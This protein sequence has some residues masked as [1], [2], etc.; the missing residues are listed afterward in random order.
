MFIGAWLLGI[1]TGVFFP[2]G[3]FLA[4]TV[5][6]GA[7]VVSRRVQLRWPMAASAASLVFLGVVLG[8]GSQAHTFPAHHCLAF[9]DDFQ[10][11][12]IQ[13]DR[14]EAARVQYVIRNENDCTVLV[15]TSRWP[16]YEVG[17][18]VRLTGSLQGVSDIP[19]EY[20]GYAKYLER[21]RISAT[22]RY[23]VVERMAT[24]RPPYL[25]S[26]RHVLDKK[27]QAA[28]SEPEA[29]VASAMVLG[30]LG[31]I[32]QT[33]LDQFRQLG[34]THILAISGSNI[35]LLVGMFVVGLK[36]IPLPPRWQTTLL[37]VLL[38]LYIGLIA[39][40]IS[41]QRAALFWTLALLALRLQLL[42]SLVTAI[43]MA[44]T[45]MLTWQPLTFQDVGFQLSF[46]AVIGIGVALLLIRPWLPRRPAARFALGLVLVSLGASLTTWPLVAYH[47]GMVSI[48]SLAA[49]FLVIPLIPL[50]MLSALLALLLSFIA[51][52]LALFVGWI[53][54]LVWL[55][56]EVAGRFLVRVP[57][58]FV[59]EVTVPLWL[60][61]L[62]Y[63]ALFGGAM[64]IMHWQ[65]RTWREVWAP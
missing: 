44:A 57:L 10:A 2:A 35:T 30:Q 34:L 1:A 22:M 6:V 63:G 41:A 25:V 26:A 19:A 28:L 18:T 50:F 52:P 64:Y 13:I 5:A 27:L 53:T 24:G 47:F 38:W 40:P 48:I 58:G 32:P 29:S 4:A 36:V 8:T 60:L 43:L 15:T 59:D 20:A 49:N 12:I 51:L 31:G 46:A 11:Q 9:S 37:L 45:F 7:M 17:D 54:H 14:I 39:A 55:W 16:L 21:R 61:A 65:K 23:P 42:T 56:F 62:Y 33:V 3:Y